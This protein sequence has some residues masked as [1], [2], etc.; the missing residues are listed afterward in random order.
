MMKKVLIEK[1]AAKYFLSS[2]PYPKIE[3]ELIIFKPK[4]DDQDKG[5]DVIVYRDYSLRKRNEA[6]SKPA[7]NEFV[8]SSRKKAA[9]KKEEIKTEDT[10]E[11]KLQCLEMDI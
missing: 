10:K 2:H 6:P 4:K 1:L 7:L 5:K 3:G 9:S 8:V 11:S